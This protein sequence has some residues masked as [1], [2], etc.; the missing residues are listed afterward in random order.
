MFEKKKKLNALREAIE[1]NDAAKV[2][3]VAANLPLSGEKEYFEACLSAIRQGKDRAL[4]ALMTAGN[5]FNFSGKKYEWDFIFPMRDESSERDVNKELGRKLIREA[6]ASPKPEALLLILHENRDKGDLGYGALDTKAFVNK[7]APV[8]LLEACLKNESG[9]LPPCLNEAGLVSTPKFEFILTYA[10]DKYTAYLSNVLVFLAARGAAE[11]LDKVKLLLAH[12]AAPS[13]D[14]AEALQNAAM[15]KDRA[16]AELLLPHTDFDSYGENI[17]TQLKHKKA[18]PAMIEIIETAMERALGR[19]TAAAVASAPE[20]PKEDR[21][22]VVDDAL[23]EVQRLSGNKTITRLYHLARGEKEI[24]VT[25]EAT[26]ASGPVATEKINE[27][28][29]KRLREEFNKRVNPPPAQPARVPMAQRRV[30][31]R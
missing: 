21:F 4:D 30:L 9:A 20:T 1:Q 28:D 17:V 2:A 10:T 15:R 24:F 16:M 23:E 8:L 26:G 14:Y 22:H 5:G 12:S 7:D 13:F 3:A 11:D 19:K 18:E 27:E 25:N 31:R 6:Y 29:L